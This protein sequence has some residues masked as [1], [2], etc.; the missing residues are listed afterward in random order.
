MSAVGDFYDQ[1][2]PST[3]KLIEES[4]TMLTSKPDLVGFHENIFVSP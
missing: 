3:A 2:T 4:G 1:W